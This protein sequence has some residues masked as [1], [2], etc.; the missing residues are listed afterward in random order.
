[1]VSFGPCRDAQACI[2]LTTAPGCKISDDRTYSTLRMSGVV[3][4]VLFR[5]GQIRLTLAVRN[6]FELELSVQCLRSFSDYSPS[7]HTS[8]SLC[9]VLQQCSLLS[10]PCCRLS[11]WLLLVPFFSFSRF[12]LILARLLQDLS[13]KSN[14]N[15]KPQRLDI[16]SKALADLCWAAHHPGCSQHAMIVDWPMIKMQQHENKYPHQLF[17]GS[18]WC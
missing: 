7:S 3:S 10:P 9:Q 12:C 8:G 16:C 2:Q 17:F 18:S 15:L 14:S 11:Q 1:M 5:A 13:N 6:V 4:A